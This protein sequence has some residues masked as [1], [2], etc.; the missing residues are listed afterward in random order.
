MRMSNFY[1]QL[2]FLVV[3]G[4]LGWFH[5]DAGAI[6]YILTTTASGTLGGTPFTN[7]GLTVTLAGDTAG[8]V[9]LNPAVDFFSLAN[10]GSATVIVSGVGAAT[11]EGLTVAVSTLNTP[12]NGVYAM[13]IEVP[14]VA[15]LVYAIGPQLQGYNLADPLSFSGGGGLGNG[16]GTVNIFPTTAGNLI[17]VRQQPPISVGATATAILTNSLSGYQGG[18]TSAPVYLIGNSP[19]GAVSGTISGVGSEDYYLFNWGGGVFAAT[20][21]VTGASAGASY[22]FSAGAAGSCNSVGSQILNSGDSFSGIISG[23]LAPGHYCIG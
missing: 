2:G 12:F 5:A 6:T 23:N 4:S 15:G 3:A 9:T 18:S 10:P 19:V 22:L 13:G 11:L 7:A 21:S 8:I 17:F 16:G 1:R 20:A 14:S